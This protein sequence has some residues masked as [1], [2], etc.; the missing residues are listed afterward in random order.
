MKG[1]KDGVSF[2]SR[3]DGHCVVYY[4]TELTLKFMINVVVVVVSKYN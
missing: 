3:R 1:S 4:V 2:V